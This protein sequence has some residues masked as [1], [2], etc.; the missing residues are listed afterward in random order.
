MPSQSF[1]QTLDY[2][3]SQLPMYQR[4][5]PAA[6]K[7]NLDNTIALSEYLDHPEKKIK[8]IHIAGTNGKGSVAHMAASVLQEAGYR[9]GL[10]TS[11]HLKDFRE[12]IRI[13][14]KPIPKKDVIDFV[15][16]HKA[17]FEQLRPSFFEM[18]MAM[19]FDYFAGEQIDVAVIE[20]GLG[21]RLD[22]SNIIMPE[23]SVITN[24]GMDHTSLLG[25]TLEEIASEKAGI[26]KAETP[27]LIGRRQKEV[28]HVFENVAARNRAPIYYAD[29]I[30]EV[31]SLSQVNLNGS[32]YIKATMRHAQT[33]CNV[34]LDLLGNYQVEN[35]VTVMAA[36]LI[37]NKY[38]KLVIPDGAII[39]GLRKVVKNTGL[40]GRWQQIGQRPR[41]ICD[42]GH[43][44]D[45]INY[46]ADQ[47]KTT[48]YE[49]LHMV[50]GMVDDKDRK[51]VLECLPKP[52]SYYFCRPS[53]PRGLD[54]GVLA[55]E[56][57]AVGLQGKA[58]ATVN[59]ALQTAR[60]KAAPDDLI[61]V[62]G[63]T[64]VVAEVV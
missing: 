21:G 63:S 5:G 50:I 62:G 13:N 58:Y 64:F 18:T 38:K 42:A 17:F 52:A 6:Y 4:I 55:S 35:L 23:L 61:F 33:T 22:S 36:I 43:N 7:A 15:K 53:V 56:A 12:R 8:T 14:G 24:I 3:Y 44:P 41:I 32:G 20:T 19:T 39:R 40:K 48:P 27:V 51:A 37:L 54:P 57:A 49:H 10:A 16:K 59:E 26:I 30:F 34:L 31:H 9:T 28:C 1:Q 60:L 46:I 2:L 25:D 29:D 11:P 47:L 45:G